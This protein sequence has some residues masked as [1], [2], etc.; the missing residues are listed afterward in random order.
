MEV[1]VVIITKNQCPYLERS[2]PMLNQQQGVLGGV[3]VIVVDSGSTDG[4]QETVNRNGAHLIEIAPR[5]FGYAR[6]YNTGAAQGTG[7]FI[8]R[9]SGDAVP[10]SET[11]LSQLIAP[12]QMDDTIAV[13]WGAQHLPDG[14]QNPIEHFCQHLYGYDRPTAPPQ[15]ITKTQTVLGCNMATRRDLW[16]RYP[17]PEA[18]PQAEDYAY[19]HQWIK[20]GYCGVFI[21][22]A[23]VEHGHEEPLPKAIYRSLQQ[24]ALQ[25]LILAG[26]LR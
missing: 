26:V 15:R 8:V 21:P 3:E 10:A 6:A 23:V 16:T 12:M 13:T 14:L 7:Q 20:C 17:F 19:F 11:W 5:S 4:A 2:L 22:G 24:S 9:L 18:I 1:T 25:G